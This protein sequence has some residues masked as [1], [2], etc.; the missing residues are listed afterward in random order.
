MPR[1]RNMPFFMPQPGHKKSE[2]KKK[3]KNPRDRLNEGYINSMNKPLVEPPANVPLPP[4]PTHAP[5]MGEPLGP[6]SLGSATHKILGSGRVKT[7]ERQYV[8]MIVRALAGSMCKV[9]ALEGFRED[10]LGR[11]ASIS[12]HYPSPM[13]VLSRFMDAYEALCTVESMVF[14]GRKMPVRIGM[15]AE[16]ERFAA[17]SRHFLSP[18]GLDGI[19]ARVEACLRNGSSTYEIKF[20]SPDML[21][22]ISGER[23]EESPWMKTPSDMPKMA[24]GRDKE[25]I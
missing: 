14:E 21:R 22:R 20:I 16:A 7:N 19:L 24:R 23:M 6:N 11:I 18:E 5:F 13:A 17:A 9:E 1:D 15:E 8:G 2:K 12:S 10:A 25:P 4:R 3:W